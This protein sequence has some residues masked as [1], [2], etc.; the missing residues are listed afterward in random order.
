MVRDRGQGFGQFRFR[1]REGRHGIA[2]NNIYALDNVRARRSNER[3]DIVGIGGERTIEK[4]ER[5]RHI[6]RGPTLIEPS[7]TL[8]VEVHRVGGRGLFGAAR[9]SDD[10]LR[11]QRVSQARDDFVLH[12]EEIGQ[13]LVEPLGPEM[14]AR[15]GIDELHVHAHAVSAALNTAFE[16]IANVQLAADLLQIDVLAFIGE[17]GV[18]PDN[19]GSAYA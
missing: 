9:L 6:L 3:V 2:H 4:A 8:K 15:F 7:Q 5:L 1:R 18:A 16:D 12:I 14:I 17:G 11:I 10:E 13:R 19:D